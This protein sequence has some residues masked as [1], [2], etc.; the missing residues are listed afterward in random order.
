MRVA[1]TFHRVPEELQCRFA[2][3][4]LGDIAFK[5]LTLVIYGAPQ[6]VGFTVDLYEHLV[7]MPLPIRMSTKLLNPFSSDLSGK[8]RTKT[9][10]PEPHRFV[11][12][13]DATFMQQILDIAKGKWKPD[14]H[15]HRQADDLWAGF[16]IPKRGAFCHPVTLVG[17]LAR[18]KLVS[19][20]THASGSARNQLKKCRAEF[21]SSPKW[22]PLA[23]ER[24]SGQV[25]SLRQLP[26]LSIVWSG[27]PWIAY[28]S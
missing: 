1:V 11:A 12:D 24:V 7:Q 13:I 16:E 2:I 20:D 5:H 14:I 10:P 15:H 8:H 21:R 4:S 26:F 6:V 22:L 27:G 9:V 3:P 19:S 17:R 23:R 18:L 25:G 28:C